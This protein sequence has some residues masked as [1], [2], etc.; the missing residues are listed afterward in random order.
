MI[1]ETMKKHECI[2]EYQS[3][4]EY[5]ERVGGR[6]MGYEGVTKYKEVWGYQSL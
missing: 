4:R 3:T 6:K 2:E 1:F 5:G